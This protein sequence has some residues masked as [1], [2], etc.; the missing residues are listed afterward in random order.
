MIL[1]VKNVE[2]GN[3]NVNRL[4]VGSLFAGIGGIDIA[5][6]QA[7]FI[8]KWAIENNPAC[9][10][11]YNINNQETP[12]I[13][14]DIRWIKPSDLECVNLLVA[15]FPCQPFSIAGKQRGFDDP[16][17][18]LFYNIIE[19]IDYFHPEIVFFENVANLLEHDHGNTFMVIHNLM[20]ER[21]YYIRYQVLR[22]SDYGGI[23]QIRDR[24][25]IVAFK[26]L[27]KCE[28]FSFPKKCGLTVTIE[29]ILQRS[30]KKEDVYYLSENDPYW[31]IVSTI[32]TDKKHIYR[33][34][35]ESI[36]PV[37]NKMCPTLTASMGSRKNQ[38]HLVLDDFGIRTLTIEECKAFQGFPD[39]FVFPASVALPEALKQLGNAVSIPVVKRIAT[40]IKEVLQTEK[41]EIQLYIGQTLWWIDKRT[42]CE[43]T[44]KIEKINDSQFAVRYNGKLY[45]R[46]YGIIGKKLFLS[47]KN[48]K[49]ND[50]IMT[51]HAPSIPYLANT[52]PF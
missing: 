4:S 15:G 34:Y 28:S 46:E 18:N 12:V 30:K 9:C 37:R 2:M 48:T 19:F 41:Q 23:P 45:W 32:V 31:K 52:P 5:F 14:K 22:T 25:Y 3:N 43:G 20:S 1:E 21:G 24:I 6:R 11:T 10:A 33:V 8:I 13:C 35:H 16:R 7:G 51:F 38:A 47:S 29:D 44:V 42:H 50:K 40:N 17:G 36:K 49:K 26:D 39:N 27:K